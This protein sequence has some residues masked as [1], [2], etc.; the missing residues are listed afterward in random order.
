M[1]R[2]VQFCARKDV[3]KHKSDCFLVLLDYG[4]G[5]GGGG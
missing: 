3:F 4:G 5:G 1:Q 2:G